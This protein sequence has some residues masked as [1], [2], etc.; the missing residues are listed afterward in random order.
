[1]KQDAE[2]KL[3]SPNTPASLYKNRTSSLPTRPSKPSVPATMLE[4]GANDPGPF[5]NLDGLDHDE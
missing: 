2:E 4:H 1:M 3:I 5:I